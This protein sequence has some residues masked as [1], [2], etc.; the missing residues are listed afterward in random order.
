MMEGYSDSDEFSVPEQ[1]P[2]SGRAA[3]LGVGDTLA[4]EAVALVAATAAET[5]EIDVIY[6][7]EDWLDAGGRRERPFFKPAF[8]PDLLTELPY[9]GP[10]AFVRRSSSF[11][12]RNRLSS[13][14]LTEVLK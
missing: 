10:A 5:P 1:A 14:G 12:L 6:A 3:F 9:L 11:A 2:G 4:P 13:S 8:S 7:D